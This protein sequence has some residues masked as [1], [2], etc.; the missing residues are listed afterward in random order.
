MGGDSAVEDVGGVIGLSDVDSFALAWSDQ[1]ADTLRGFLFLPG[2]DGVDVEVSALAGKSHAELVE[3]CTQAQRARRIDRP[4]LR[5]VTEL[6]EGG[7]EVDAAGLW[8][9]GTL[10]LSALTALQKKE[11]ELAKKAGIRRSQSPQRRREG[12]REVPQKKADCWDEDDEKPLAKRG[13]AEAGTKKTGLKAAGKASGG[14]GSEEHRAGGSEKRQLDADDA[15]GAELASL[16]KELKE[17]MSAQGDGGRRKKSRSR[18]RQGRSRSRN[19]SAGKAP[20]PSRHKGRSSSR[21]A[22]KSSR[23]SRSRSRRGR[24]RRDRNS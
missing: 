21:S 7:A 17:L 14:S 5:L 22:S 2:D 11:D 16:G 3:M 15:R 4:W 13:S 10:D 12:I 9:V 20:P 6:W 23:W 18:S 19:G 8:D 24:G 1:R